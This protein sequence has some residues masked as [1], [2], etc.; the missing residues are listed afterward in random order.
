MD[1]PEGPL[2][3]Y[4]A[5]EKEVI[6]DERAENGTTLRSS[7]EMLTPSYPQD[8]QPKEVEL[9]EETN[10][11]QNLVV[12]SEEHGDMSSR[13]DG[14]ASPTILN[15]NVLKE[16]RGS[17]PLAKSTSPDETPV[18]DTTSLV[19]LQDGITSI[20][21]HG[22]IKTV[23]IEDSSEDSLHLEKEPELEFRPMP[24]QNIESIDALN[25]FVPA[26]IDGGASD[27]TIQLP[28]AI[29]TN[30]S[31][32]ISTLDSNSLQSTDTSKEDSIIISAEERGE[33]GAVNPAETI[34]S[35]MDDATETIGKETAQ[36]NETTV[37]KDE[38]TER[39][40]VQSVETIDKEQ[41]AQIPESI[42]DDVPPPPVS[43]G[44]TISARPLQPPD[45]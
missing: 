45:Q 34:G 32:T 41:T 29:G 8:A 23:L 4:L 37:E 27:T 20:S 5:P 7:S 25:Q 43:D 6:S 15:E 13:T 10:E 11:Q 1:V 26:S 39:E 2:P 17:P 9:G 40:T 31:Q 38:T 28:E 36:A 42:S 14:E 12:V 18:E 30:D 35:N 21:S 19:V 24:E 16:D 3:K 44:E 22:D 33:E